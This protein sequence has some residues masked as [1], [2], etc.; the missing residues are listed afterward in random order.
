MSADLGRKHAKVRRRI[1]TGVVLAGTA[2]CFLAAWHLALVIM[3]GLP[4]GAVSTTLHALVS[5]APVAG[6]PAAYR[7]DSTIA[8]IAVAVMLIVV[9]FIAWIVWSWRR[10]SRVQAVGLAD[11]KQTRA[12]AGEDRARAK[13]AWNRRESVER[14]ELDVDRAPL[15]QIGFLLGSTVGPDEKVVTTHEDQI[16]VWAP[17]GGG[18]SLHLMI[19]ACL[20]A[21]GALVATSTRPELLDAI[22]EARTSMGQVWVFDPLDMATWVEPMVWDPIAGAQDSKV[23]VSRGLAFASG[24]AGD[25]TDEQN[26]FFTG[27]A[28]LIMTRLMH[29]AALEG[30]DMLDVFRWALDLERTTEAT[31]ILAAH[32]AA[33]VLYAETLKTATEGADETVNSVRMTLGQSIEPVLSR[34]VLRQLVPAPGIPQFTAAEFVR[35]TDTLILITDDNAESNVSAL[36]TMLLNEVVTAAKAA[37]AQSEGGRLDPVLRIVGDEIANVAPLPK[38]AGYLTDSRGAGIQWLCAF[39][40]VAQILARWGDKT[41]KQL[42][43]SLNASMVLGGL[44]DDEALE[45]FSRLVGKTDLVQVIATLDRDTS[46]SSHSVS[47][48]ER[49]VLRPEEIRQLPE[50]RALLIYKNA[51]AM[52]VDLIPWTSRGDADDIAAGIGRIRKVRIAHPGWTR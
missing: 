24:L 11:R 12:A 20:D 1:P 30:R 48:A 42:L 17:T 14:G 47:L 46:T 35:S 33:E 8:A 39:Q 37:A 3:G 19:G 7:P 38:L 6:L 4:I 15:S 27:A 31:E 5:G 23:A 28:A 45:R 51:P 22:M 36:T 9:P 16:A 25:K 49:E 10:A 43:V 18:K 34:R 52:L 44:Q 29:A 41:G 32:P 50:G 26:Q 2:L 13:A 40:S 21:P